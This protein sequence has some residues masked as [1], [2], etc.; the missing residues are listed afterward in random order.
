V[1]L[2]DWKVGGAYHATCDVD[3]PEQAIRHPIK[4][5]FDTEVIVLG[6]SPDDHPS[7]IIKVIAPATGHKFY[8]AAY[9]L[10][11]AVEDVRA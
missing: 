5:Y 7:H 3:C 1:S 6:R 9:E 11:E 8:V 2:E 4:P 10:S